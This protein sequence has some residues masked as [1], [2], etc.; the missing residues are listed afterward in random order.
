[1]KATNLN[2][3]F[4]D[5]G[6]NFDV[7]L[8]TEQVRTLMSERRI[9][10]RTQIRLLGTRQWR[11]LGDLPLFNTRKPRFSKRLALWFVQCLKLLPA[12]FI[13]VPLLAL[14]MLVLGS[15]DY[16]KTD[17]K[18]PPPDFGK[19]LQTVFT[20]KDFIGFLGVAFVAGIALRWTIQK[21]RRTPESLTQLIVNELILVA[22]IGFLAL[23]T[24][25]YLNAMLVMSPAMEP[26]V[27]SDPDKMDLV[28]SPS[29]WRDVILFS[30]LGLLFW[31]C[32]RE[33]H[34]RIRFKHDPPTWLEFPNARV[35]ESLFRSRILS[36]FLKSAPIV[37]LFFSLPGTVCI[38]LPFHEAI[39]DEDLSIIFISGILAACGLLWIQIKSAIKRSG[40]Q[41]PFSV[42]RSDPR[43]PVVHLRNFGTDKKSFGILGKMPN[44]MDLDQVFWN[45]V[46]P[47]IAIGRPGERVPSLGVPRMYVESDDWD[48]WKIVV[49]RL[50]QEAC[51]VV[52]S[53]DLDGANPPDGLRWEIETAL[54]SVPDK[55]V[56]AVSSRSHH[57]AY[58]NFRHA[59]ND[60]FLART[61]KDLPTKVA[62]G[63]FI[64]VMNTPPTVFR[65]Q[66][67][68][69]NLFANVV[70]LSNSSAIVEDQLHSYANLRMFIADESTQ[71]E[72]N[73]AAIDTGNI[74]F[75][76]PI[77][78]AALYL[79][80]NI[81]GNALV[82]SG[83]GM[84]LFAFWVLRL[85]RVVDSFGLPF[86][87]WRPVS[88]HGVVCAALYHRDLLF[89]RATIVLGGLALALS[90]FVNWYIYFF[91]EKRPFLGVGFEKRN[92]GAFI[93]K[94]ISNSPASAIPLFPGDRILAIN[95]TIVH[96]S[97]DAIEAIGALEAGDK[98]LL[99]I[100]RNGKIIEAKTTLSIWPD[101]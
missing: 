88:S 86:C 65:D 69:I 76:G 28:I 71:K 25:A 74:F 12:A 26:E 68:L 50:M 2:D 52:F 47:V 61:G 16:I 98:C 75:Y 64:G 32:F 41:S 42:L 62:K 24:A 38:L 17:P 99:R 39:V 10:S 1:M 96:S 19:S 8:T 82:I 18:S 35:R 101:D 31:V 57:R 14:A 91:S 83:C 3:A 22:S 6:E 94:L 55:I 4:W 15:Y 46:G 30:C 34:Q 78:I 93:T 43:P 7:A 5:L 87:Q 97:S 33:M 70:C 95:G 81:A 51:L 79:L 66:Y 59:F 49:T 9:G 53:A 63:N 44:E 90:L 54:D 20:N 48:G 45:T 92:D 58:T 77:F 72:R 21:V 40:S 37:V 36:R 13:F 80:A 100:S 73:P 89:R 60:L 29:W 67:S 85:K 84:V 11:I 23:S 27:I 56:L